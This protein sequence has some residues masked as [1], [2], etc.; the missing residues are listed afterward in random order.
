MTAT[1]L[2]SLGA[3]KSWLGITTGTDDAVLARL[4]SAAS[5]FI[6]SGLNRQLGQAAYTEIRNG[7]GGNRLVFANPPVTA[8]TSLEI[9]GETIPA[10]GDGD[11]P[12]YLVDE[13]LLYLRSYSFTEG[14]R[15]VTIRYIAG[16][17]VIPPE[18]EHACVELVALRYRERDRTGYASRSLQG[19]SA[20]F[21]LKDL[22]P[23]VETV[24]NKYRKVVP[25]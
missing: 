11:A 25:V 15:N 2:T 4:I 6:Q 19:E 1:D 5:G 9:D 23:G 24:L 13:R 7:P 18:L 17:A 21:A 20:A 12:G 14:I 16:F 3:V 10:A 22:P 8:V